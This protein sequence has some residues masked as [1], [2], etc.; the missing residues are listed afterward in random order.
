MRKEQN[1]SGRPKLEKLSWQRRYP[2]ETMKIGE[3]FFVNGKY[4]IDVSPDRQKAQ[5]A[6]GFKFKLRSIDKPKMG[7]MII[8]IS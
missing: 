6:T 7:T 4:A 8:R 3:H 1:K 5:I 2:F